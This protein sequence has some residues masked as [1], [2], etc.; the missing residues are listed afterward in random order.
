MVRL[1]RQSMKHADCSFGQAFEEDVSIDQR[2]GSGTLVD[3]MIR[4]LLEV[5]DLAMSVM[6][7][8]EERENWE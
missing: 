3:S 2:H 1:M 8:R 5:H 4:E 6:V 7:G